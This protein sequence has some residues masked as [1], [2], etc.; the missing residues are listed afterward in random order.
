MKSTCL[1]KNDEIM[2][3]ILFL[4]SLFVIHVSSIAQIVI[5]SGATFIKDC[6][7]QKTVTYN[8]LPFIDDFSNYEGLPMQ[9]K[10]QSSGAIVNHDYQYNPP[11]V[12]VVTL[13]AMD[14]F[15]KLYPGAS[16]SPFNAD[17]LTSQPI[18]LDS[19][20]TPYNTGLSVS[21][22]VYFS[23]YYQ[24]AGNGNNPW[25]TVGSRPASADSLILEFFSP[26]DGWN[27]IWSSGGISGDSLY[28]S[29]GTYYGY[30]LIP[31][32]DEKFFTK[33]FRFRFRNMATL[34]NN[35]QIAYVGNCDQWNIDYVYLD[36]N[37]TFEDTTQRDLAFVDPAPSLLKRYQAMPSR[38]F[39]AD[40]MADSLKIKIV[41]LHSQAL[42]ST[43]KF[44]VEN[45]SGTRLYTYDGGFE[46]IYPY[47]DNLQYQTSPNHACPELTFVYDINPERHYEFDIVHTIKE[48]VGQDKLSA[49]D[50]IRFKQIFSDY[51]AYD[52][53]TAEN[54][55]GVEP[56]SGSHFA[57][58]YE[59]NNPDTLSAIDIYFNSSLNESNFKPFYIC[60]WNAEGKLPSEIIYQTEQQTP[61]S[62]SLNRF[63]RYVLEEPIALPSGRF[64]V[65][66]KTKGNDYLNIGFDRNTNSS[67][68]TFSRTNYDWQQSFEKG[69]AMIR[70]YFGYKAAVGLEDVKEN[71]V[72][73]YPN[74]ASSNIYLR[75]CNGCLKQLFDMNGRL[76]LQTEDD[77]IN[78][79]GFDNGI[80]LLQIKNNDGS[81]FR[82]KIIKA[83]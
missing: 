69:S 10:W 60:V 17:T 63:V 83:E 65:S 50:T 76:L 13:D 12:G 16:N 47:S 81:F 68:Y 22:S 52:D 3:K 49:N 37:R 44:Y 35:P 36:K 7:I 74:P 6:N 14:L 42:S 58:A 30:V 29:Y 45:E 75:N 25:E 64:F 20:N 2:K 38:Q 9:D 40:E 15:G 4:V 66:L 31:I 39:E 32:T 24:P 8:R 53:G 73:V 62:D 41:N 80:Y 56:I 18:R 21:D 57:I 28:S 1:T 34:N 48:G 59:L 26:E 72:L 71:N 11:T 27:W 5:T 78:L 33:E 43:Y 23:F 67:E 46:N 54:G 61:R 70:P 77:E 82:T 55:I 79:S 51:F 19:A